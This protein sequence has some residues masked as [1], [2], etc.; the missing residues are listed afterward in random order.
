MASTT[1]K[2][3]PELKEHIASLARRAGVTP[4]S[5]MVQSLER[6]AALSD[7]RESFLQDAEHSAEEV[8]AGGALY[9]A[10]D[11]HA[12]LASRISDA[13]AHRPAPIKRSRRRQ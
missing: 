2:L 6:E 10:E 9:A 1:L 3:S 13:S 8:D 5:W 7:L 11:V 12:Y 4:H